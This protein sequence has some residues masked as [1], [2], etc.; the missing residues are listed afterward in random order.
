[1]RARTEYPF[2]PVSPQGRR[3]SESEKIEPSRRTASLIATRDN[4]WSFLG[5]CAFSRHCFRRSSLH[6]RI[7]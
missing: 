3:Y 2:T 7:G 4:V 5:R 1:M 6:I